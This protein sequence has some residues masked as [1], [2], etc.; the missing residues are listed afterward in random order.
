MPQRTR[1][2]APP[3]EKSDDTIQRKRQNLL[4][5]ARKRGAMRIRD[6]LGKG[7]VRGYS[8]TGVLQ[9]WPLWSGCAHTVNILDVRFCFSKLR[10]GV[11]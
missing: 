7:A 9:T 1:M 2:A 5:N 4:G 11:R 3:I 8:R 6:L 10:D